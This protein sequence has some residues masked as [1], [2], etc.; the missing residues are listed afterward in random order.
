M[1]VMKNNTIQFLIQKNKKAV[2]T[3]KKSCKKCKPEKLVNK[4][5][6]LSH[7]LNATHIKY[8]QHNSMRYN[9]LIILVTHKKN[10]PQ[11]SLKL[12]KLRIK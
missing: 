1:I 11:I 7:L 10:K 3:R 8:I 6:E 12:Y 2:L 4:Y 9:L 5:I